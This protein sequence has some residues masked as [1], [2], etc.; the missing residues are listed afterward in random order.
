M[1]LPKKI[2]ILALDYQVG[3]MDE[4]EKRVGK[5][6]GHCKNNEATISIDD[7][8]NSQV[9]GNTLLHEILHAVSH[10]M[11]KWDLS[12]EQEEK[13]VDGMATGISIVMRENLYHETTQ[14]HSL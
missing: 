2:R 10:H 3:L 12:V 14:N 13:V 1:N 4:E 6:L 9:Q 11:G 5:Y 8:Y 7:R